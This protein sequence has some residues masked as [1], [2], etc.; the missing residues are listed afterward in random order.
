MYSTIDGSTFS[1]GHNLTVDFTFDKGEVAILLGLSGSFAIA[2]LRGKKSL[3]EAQV[4]R[5]NVA[6]PVFI[7]PRG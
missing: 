6:T 3:N 5:R 4:A 2:L 1:I 7:Q